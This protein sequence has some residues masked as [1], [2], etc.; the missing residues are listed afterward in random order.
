M[1]IRKLKDLFA[2]ARPNAQPAR[3]EDTA[4]RIQLATCVLLLEVAHSDDNYTQAEHDRIVEVLKEK[5]QLSAE[6]AAELLE[7][8]DR[9][10]ANSADLWRFTNVIDNTYSSEEKE[11]VIETLWKVV[12]A[13]DRLHFYED[14]LIHRLAKLLNLS[15][16]QLIDAKKRVIGWD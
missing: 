10:R 7:L 13:D 5:F 11:S 8:A 15:H 12:Y 14:N 3:Q 6:Y 2:Q 16:K 9:E 4:E 1:V